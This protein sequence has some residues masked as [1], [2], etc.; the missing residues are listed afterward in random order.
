M[1]DRGSD[2]SFFQ[3]THVRFGMRIDIFISIRPMMTKSGK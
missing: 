2:F 3:G 1:V